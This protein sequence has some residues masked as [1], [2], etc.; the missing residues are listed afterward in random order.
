MVGSIE[1]KRRRVQQRMRFESI[2]DSMNMNL[3]KLWEIV[4]DRVEWHAAVH[5]CAKNQTRLSD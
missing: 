5:G 1:G 4:N 2:T 3:R